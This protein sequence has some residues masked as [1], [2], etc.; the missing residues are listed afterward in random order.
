MLTLSRRPG[1]RILIGDD[2]EIVVMRIGRNHV[3]IGI[4]APNDLPIL[5][6]EVQNTYPYLIVAGPHAGKHARRLRTVNDRC[7]L[8]ATESGDEVVLGDSG[9]I[10]E[11]ERIGR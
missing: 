1:E 8:Y 5:R 6:E 2:I 4:D 10:I 11:V 3:R 9:E 7:G